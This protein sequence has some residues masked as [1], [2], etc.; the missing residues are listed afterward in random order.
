MMRRSPYFLAIAAVFLAAGGAPAFCTDQNM[1]VQ[2]VFPGTP[3]DPSAQYV[4]L[5]MTSFNQLNV[6]GSFIEVQG[7]TGT[8]L[9][10]FGTFTQ[11]VAVPGT[12]GCIWAACPAILIGTS[13]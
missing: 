11:D 13:N 9:G 7:P 12:S 1:V 8:I 2:E 10:R 5:R 6:N 4:M 3:A